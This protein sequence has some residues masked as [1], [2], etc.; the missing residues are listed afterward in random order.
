[1][2]N[3]GIEIKSLVRDKIEVVDSGIKDNE[4]DIDSLICCP[5]SFWALRG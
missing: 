3:D 1:M 5:V 2:K 4:R